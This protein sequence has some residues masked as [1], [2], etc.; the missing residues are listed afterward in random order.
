MFR[1]KICGITSTFDAR[2]AVQAGADAIGI[3]F[4]PRSRRCVNPAEAQQ[5]VA[6]AREESLRKDR[7]VVVAGVFVNASPDHVARLAGE[8]QLD[9]VQLHGDESADQLVA[10]AE[11]CGETV[12]ILRAVRMAADQG[13]QLADQVSDCQIAGRLPDAILVDAFVPGHYGGSGQTAPW[14]SLQDWPT[15]LGGCP[16]ILAGGLTPE[17]VAAAIAQVRPVGVDVASGVEAS[18]GSKEPRLTARFID[19][20]VAALEA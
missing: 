18:P 20:A 10:T 2:M 19:A 8:L 14:E 1:V 13:Q 16:L 5:I 12:A 15:L 9:A 7:P 4:Y 11:A 3:N 6:A 17:N